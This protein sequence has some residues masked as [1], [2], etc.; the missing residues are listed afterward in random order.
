MRVSVRGWLSLE[1]TDADVLGN[2]LRDEGKVD[3]S[4][5]LVRHGRKMIKDDRYQYF[6]ILPGSPT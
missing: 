1:E 2:K 3:C 6:I 5:L 4:L